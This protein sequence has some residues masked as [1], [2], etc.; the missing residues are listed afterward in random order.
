MTAQYDPVR[1][2]LEYPDTA[3]GERHAALCWLTG[4][5]AM[6]RGTRLHNELAAKLAAM[7]RASARALLIESEDDWY[8]KAG[9]LTPDEVAGR[10]FMI[11]LDPGSGDGDVTAVVVTHDG[12]HHD[13]VVDSKQYRQH[14]KVFN[15]GGYHPRGPVLHDGLTGEECLKRFTENMR[16]EGTP[17]YLLTTSQLAAARS[18]WSTSLRTRVSEST[19][20]D[21][22]RERNQVVCDD[23]DYYGTED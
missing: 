10:R 8:T 18:L 20:K 9:M 6:E 3:T 12:K 17:V 4:T 1:E 23:P 7:D 19:E 5:E 21:A 11:G 22:E 2:Y 16:A 13:V 15:F 14:A